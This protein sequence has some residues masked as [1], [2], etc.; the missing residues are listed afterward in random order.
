[1]KLHGKSIIGGKP[2]SA[3]G[4]TFRAFAPAR[5]QQ[6]DPVFYEAS[7]IEIDEACDLSRAAFDD[8]RRK[9]AEDRANFLETIASNI[10]D[11]GEE[12]IERASAE[13]GLPIKRL[14]GER[15][16]TVDQLRMFAALVREGSWVNAVIDGA[17][18]ERR[19]IPKPD[20]RRML[21]PIGP[22]VV[23]GA[24]NFPLAFSV[25]GG[26]TASALAA[27]NSV[28]VKG[29]PA[30]P[31]TSELVTSAI[32]AALE[33]T[34][35]PKGTFALL[36]GTSNQLSLALVK[37]PAVAAVAFTGSLS[38][39]RAIF[40]AAVARENPIPVFAE[41]GSINPVFVLPGALRDRGD[42]IAAGLQQSVT[43]GVGQFCTCPGLVVGLEDDLLDSF[44]KRTEEHFQ[45]APAATMLHPGILQSFQ[46]KVSLLERIE[47]VQITRA[48]VKAEPARN[49]A[50]AAVLLADAET[51]LATEELSEEVFGPSTVIVRCS[52]REEIMAVARSL[53]GHLTA[54]IHGTVQELED[55]QDLV[56]LLETKVG[57]LV[58]NGFPT[59]VEVCAAMQHGGPYPATTDPRFTSV[60]PAAIKRFARPVCYQNFPQSALPPE[61]RDVNE[62]RIWRTIDNELTRG[63]V[64]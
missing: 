2:A 39:G 58:F 33:G 12:L 64:V 17:D 16:R 49:E 26:D 11:L 4:Q 55:Y 43:L 21:V 15:V 31:G 45:Q 44:I 24:S 54:T 47:G 59:G 9:S 63:D 30:H 56:E 53:E 22:V 29:H 37:Q 52:S 42:S 13:S 48:N 51:F 60:G 62:R 6:L 27:G 32:V 28:I 18:P 14:V 40:D 10:I 41:M 34:G 38:G 5:G 50:T 1:M 3:G 7:Q 20:L 57:R 46:Q 23:F 19:P 8:L 35:M 36:Q 25:A 61:L